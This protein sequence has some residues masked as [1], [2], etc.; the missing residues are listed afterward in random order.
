M[1]ESMLRRLEALESHLSPSW[2]DQHPGI[3]IAIEDM[4]GDEEGNA[5]VLG[6]RLTASSYQVDTLRAD[7]ETD[8]DLRR[9]HYAACREVMAG[10]VPVS[11]SITEDRP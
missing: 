3:W 1:K 9:R 6:W 2:D 8:E 7:G 5:P 11:I 10:G 4:S